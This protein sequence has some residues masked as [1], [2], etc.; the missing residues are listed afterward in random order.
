MNRVYKIVGLF[1]LLFLFT[2]CTALVD[3]T[4][5]PNTKQHLL[6]GIEGNLSRVSSYNDNN[7]FEDG[8]TKI[9]ELSSYITNNGAYN[10]QEVSNIENPIYTRK[11]FNIDLQIISKQF[12]NKKVKIAIEEMPLNKFLHLVFGKVLNVDYV[13]DKSVQSNKQPVSINL[14]KRF[15]KKSFSKL[16]IIC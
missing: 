11:T 12:D 2:A 1:L 6:K 14:K 3:R 7:V 10:I 9:E 4:K 13:L 5:K 15:L 8:E 16:S